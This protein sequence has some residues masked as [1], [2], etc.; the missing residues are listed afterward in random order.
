MEV[1][2]LHQLQLA[3]KRLFDLVVSALLIAFFL[4]PLVT[5]TVLSVQMEYPGEHYLYYNLRAGKNGRA[6]KCWKLR[7][8]PVGYDPLIEDPIE[9][10][11]RLRLIRRFGIDEIPQ[12]LSIFVGEMSFFGNRALVLEEPPV[13]YGPYAP[14]ILQMKPGLLSLFSLK[15]HQ[16]NVSSFSPVSHSFDPAATHEALDYVQKWSLKRDWVIFCSMLRPSD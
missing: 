12:V 4:V 14:V 7:T 10:P 13:R 16:E 15:V 3:V 8:L 1:M 6:F 11:P 2:W 9:L 5:L